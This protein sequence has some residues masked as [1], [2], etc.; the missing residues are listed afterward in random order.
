M[1][2]LSV[3]ACSRCRVELAFVCRRIMLELVLETR[4]RVHAGV[5]EQTN[6][7]LWSACHG[8]L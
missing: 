5:V 1:W 4:E 6:G 8:T 3:D 2:V 7:I